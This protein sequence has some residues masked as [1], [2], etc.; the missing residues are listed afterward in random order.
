[1]RD[2]SADESPTSVGRATIGVQGSRTPPSAWLADA[3]QAL[4][5]VN[6]EISEDGLPVIPPSAR[7]EARRIIGALA[8]H[9]LAP[10]VYP[11]EDG[12]IAIHF[13]SP[14]APNSVIILL[15]SR[16]EGEC[17][18]YTGGRSLRAHYNVSSDLPDG[19]V[20]EQLRSLMREG[21]VRLAVPVAAGTSA[22]R[23]STSHALRSDAHSDES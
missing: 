13:K 1:M 10:A 14:D 6:E 12:E 7:M 23:R 8:C 9:P 2:R 22:A 17:Y 11:T 16:R 3:L 19:F 15:D 4:A 21:A 20:V 18:A 5:E